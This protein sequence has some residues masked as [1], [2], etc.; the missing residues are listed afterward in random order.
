M[1]RSIFF[2]FAL[3]TALAVGPA[4]AQ[5]TSPLIM[6]KQGYVTLKADTK[7][8]DTVLKRGTYLVQH[9]TSNGRHVLTFW[10]M[11]DPSLAQEYSD[12][13]FVG[14]PVSV[15][16]SLETLGGRVKHTEVETVPDGAL[17]RVEKVEIKGET[18]AHAFGR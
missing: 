1:K 8:G 14:E 12:Q 18:V 5:Q 2:A 17:S 3:F 7:F 9:E 15:P 6:G 4:Y 11:G 13:A 10:Q 16:C